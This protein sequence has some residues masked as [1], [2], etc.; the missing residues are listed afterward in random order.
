M[1]RGRDRLSELDGEVS[2]VT[3]LLKDNV[4]KV[5][6]RGD[7]LDDIQQKAEDLESSSIQ[8]SRKSRDLR[9]KMCC[10][11]IRMT[12]ILILVV[13]V[14]IVVIVVII[15]MTIKPWEHSDSG[16][17]NHGNNTLTSG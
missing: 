14:I 3:S 1:S 9:R 4:D 2:E 8:F 11:N 17:N 10:S 15:L 5:L 6:T 13:T 7:K 16:K 12:L